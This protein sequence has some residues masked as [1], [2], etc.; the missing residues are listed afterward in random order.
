M[1]PH[2]RASSAPLWFSTSLP[3][4]VHPYLPTCLPLSLTDRHL[5]S[6]KKGGKGE[7]GN[8]LCYVL[9]LYAHTH[10]HTL[11][12]NQRMRIA[13]SLSLSLLFS[14]AFSV[15]VCSFS[16]PLPSPLRR[17]THAH[18]ERGGERGREKSTRK[19]KENEHGC[20][21]P[22]LLHCAL[23]LPAL[24]FPHPFS[25]LHLFVSSLSSSTLAARVRKL[26]KALCKTVSSRLTWCFYCCSLVS[27]HPHPSSLF[28]SCSSLQ[29]L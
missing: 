9:S 28:L 1:P 13:A 6:R 26:R 25:F 8:R 24:S 11:P 18:R 15:V 22:S 29:Y 5:Q 16:S 23:C 3:P 21:C 2:A 14:A 10:S 7:K 4:P 12:V 27:L 20:E 17:Y 19:Q